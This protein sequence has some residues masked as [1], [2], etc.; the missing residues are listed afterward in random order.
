MVLNA[1]WVLHMLF[2][3]QFFSVQD[4]L[5]GMFH[6]FLLS[7]IQ[8]RSVWHSMKN[9]SHAVFIS[10]RV[11]VGTTSP[12]GVKS[13]CV[14]V[15]MLDSPDFPLSLVLC[16]FCFV[17]FCF[18]YHMHTES[19]SGNRQAHLFVTTFSQTLPSRGWGNERRKC[20]DASSGAEFSV[21]ESGRNPMPGAGSEGP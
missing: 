6:F 8:K 13:K 20:P 9:F 16:G 1:C 19:N 15:V 18:S 14:D 5:T 17:L 3:H 4:S 21:A 11:T 7:I 12:R 10:E 2:L